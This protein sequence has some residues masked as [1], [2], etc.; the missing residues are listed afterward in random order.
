MVSGP[1][2]HRLDRRWVAPLAVVAVLVGVLGSGVL[3]WRSSGAAFAGTTA[4]PASSWAAGTVSLSDDDSGTALFS[5][6]GL[7]PGATGQK[8]ITVTYGGTVA[9]GDVRIYGA[10]P[11]G[12]LGP[13]VLLTVAVGSA[14]AFT[15]CGAF[16]PS[17]TPISAVPLAT[18]GT[19][20]SY[21]TGYSTGWSPAPGESAVFRFTYTL[22]PSVPDAQAGAARSGLAPGGAPGCSG[23]ELGF[24]AAHDAPCDGEE[25][26][27]RARTGV[28]E[29]GQ[30]L[31]GRTRSTARRRT[32]AARGFSAISASVACSAPRVT[33]RSSGSA[34][35]GTNGRSG[36]TSSRVASA[37]NRFTSRSSR[38]W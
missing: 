8:C 15:G 28:R 19:R 21:A 37:K 29:G 26:G 23:T 7:K 3:V 22:S 32:E 33:R 9:A 4:S 24:G 30:V 10:A 2:R 16:A 31:R 20:T 1:A 25:R 36:G 13:D 34:P 35:S 5:A 14:G 27:G 11:T 17:S 38:E 12:T 6:T 18:V